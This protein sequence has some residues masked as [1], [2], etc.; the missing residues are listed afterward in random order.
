MIHESSRHRGRL[1][2]H[3]N[4]IVNVMLNEQAACLV[5]PTHNGSF[6]PDGR[7][8]PTSIRLEGLTA[9][10][11]VLPDERCYE[12]KRRI[13]ESIRNRTALPYGFWAQPLPCWRCPRAI[14]RGPAFHDWYLAT[15]SGRF[16]FSRWQGAAVLGSGGCGR[17]C[18]VALPC[19]TFART[20]DD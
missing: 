12:M 14:Q 7:T 17:R 5:D 1:L 16:A 18:P 3:A 2:S 6:C 8:T 11:S 20:E 19:G 4:H 9:I 15:L 13:A 10:H